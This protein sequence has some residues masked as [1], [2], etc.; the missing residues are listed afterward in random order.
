MTGN[1]APDLDTA[2]VIG[3][4]S[5]AIPF[6]RSRGEEAER[7]LRI[8]RLHGQAGVALQALGVSE[9]PLEE[10]VPARQASPPDGLPGDEILTRIVSDATET[11]RRRGAACVASEDVLRAVMAFYGSDFDQVLR[12]R[13]TDREE[14]LARLDLQALAA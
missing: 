3:M 14:L 5:T 12:A 13:G 11:A 7:W 8:L 1:P 9:A 6:A 4:A 10:L 2:L